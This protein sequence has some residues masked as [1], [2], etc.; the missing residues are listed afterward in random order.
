MVRLIENRDATFT[1]AHDDGDLARRAD[2]S[3]FIT[4]DRELAVEALTYLNQPK[5]GWKKR[6]GSHRIKSIFGT[7]F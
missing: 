6:C 4:S 1:L 5:D 7:A 3:I 2:C